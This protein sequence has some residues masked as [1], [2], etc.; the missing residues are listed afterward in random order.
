MRSKA[1]PFGDILTKASVRSATGN[2]KG[3]WELW[4]AGPE[5]FAALVWRAVCGGDVGAGDGAA[6]CFARGDGDRWRGGS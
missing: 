3:G 1:I 5:V 2:G 4:G 6:A